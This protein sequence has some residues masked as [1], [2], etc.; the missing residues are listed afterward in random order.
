M[1]FYGSTAPGELA[2]KLSSL[3]KVRLRIDRDGRQIDQIF[4]LAGEPVAYEI[5]IRPLRSSACFASAPSAF[6]LAGES[7]PEPTRHVMNFDDV[8]L[9]AL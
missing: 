2:M 4:T 8:E 9:S 6:A 7:S 3:K 1:G 5:Q